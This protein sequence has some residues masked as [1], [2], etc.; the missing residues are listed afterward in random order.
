MTVFRASRLRRNSGNICGNPQLISISGTIYLPGYYAKY[1]VKRS[2]DT[3]E[4]PYNLQCCCTGFCS[5]RL[6]GVGDAVG[7]SEF[8]DIGQQR[9]RLARARRTRTWS[10]PRPY[11]TRRSRSSLWMGARTRTTLRVFAW[12]PSRL[13][14][15]TRRTKRA[16]LDCPAFFLGSAQPIAISRS[17]RVQDFLESSRNATAR[18]RRLLRVGPIG[19]RRASYNVCR[20]SQ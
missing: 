10:R 6:I 3:H 14:T 15:T 9:E 4:T 17:R 1:C 18:C 19:N 13:V 20:A 12:P 16:G 5:D 8:A 7:S 11:G 2:G